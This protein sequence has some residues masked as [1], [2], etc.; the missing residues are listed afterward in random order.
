MTNPYYSRDTSLCTFIYLTRCGV[1][2][3][4]I[5][6]EL[7][8]KSTN[9]LYRSTSNLQWSKFV[10]KFVNVLFLFTVGSV[11]CLTEKCMVFL[12]LY[13]MQLCIQARTSLAP[14]QRYYVGPDFN[15][16]I[17]TVIKNSMHVAR[18]SRPKFQGRL[19]QLCDEVNH[20]WEMSMLHAWTS[21]KHFFRNGYRVLRFSNLFCS[22]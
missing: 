1:F 7:D 3:C 6:L 8:K 20:F 9:W 18:M 15:R 14:D 22:L 21:Y 16:N 12:L 4:S 2:K 10:R 17:D 19:Q 13:G 11:W 5:I